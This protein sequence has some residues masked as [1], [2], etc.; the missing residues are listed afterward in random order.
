MAPAGDTRTAKVCE[1]LDQLILHFF[2]TL[3]M[4]QAKREALN[5]LVEQGWFSLSKSRYAMGNKSVSTLQYGHQ[6]TPLVQVQTSSTTA[7]GT[8]KNGRPGPNPECSHP[9]CRGIRAPRPPELVW[10]SRAP[11]SPTSPKDFPRR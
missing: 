3:E 9:T 11:K 10:N 1:E 6:M 5:N 7:E 2:D 8:R 4:L